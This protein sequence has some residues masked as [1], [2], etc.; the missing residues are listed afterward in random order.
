M[1]QVKVLFDYDAEQEDE[2]SLKVGEI[3]HNVDCHD[4]G[5]WEGEVNGRKGMFPENFVEVIEHTPE[6]VLTIPNPPSSSGS[7]SQIKYKARVT[8]QYDPVQEDELSLEVGEVVEVLEDDEE[9]WWT[10]RLN[11]KTGVF[12]SNFCE[13]IKEEEDVKPPVLPEPIQPETVNKERPKS[14]MGFMMRPEDLAKKLKKTSN[15]PKEEK[16]TTSFKSEPLKHTTHNEVKK[17]VM[18]NEAKKPITPNEVKKPITPN[19]MKKPVA[20]NEMKKESVIEKKLPPVPPP[21]VTA[22]KTIQKAKATFVYEPEQDD[23][24]KLS[25]GDIVVV[26]NIEVFEGWMEGELDGKRGLFPNNFVD[27]LPIETIKL[28][29][30]QQPIRSLSTKK[31]MKRAA[32]QDPTVKASTLDKPKPLGNSLFPVGSNPLKAELEKKIGFGKPPSFNKSSLNKGPAPP[33]PAAKPKPSIPSSK[34]AKPPAPAVQKPDISNRGVKPFHSPKEVAKTPSETS[35]AN[36]SI[37][38]LR[39]ASV[40]STGE[41]KVESIPRTFTGSKLRKGSGSSTSELNA[42]HFEA[43]SRRSITEE[44]D[45]N[46]ANDPSTFD[47]DSVRPTDPLKHLSRVKPPSKNLPSKF[48]D[49]T[50]SD[51]DV[52][53]LKSQLSDITEKMSEMERKFKILLN[54]VESDL[55]VERKARL[56]QQVEIDRLKKKLE[57]FANK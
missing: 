53:E 52:I 2:L 49:K 10:G 55:D 19:E 47:L 7:S 3:V 46:P 18:H 38:P 9:G 27:L 44:D 14:Q 41:R 54:Q 45:N 6:P 8:F 24:L 39:S 13:V 31:S 34:P 28:D 4:G 17:P 25:I 40:S 11:G 22:T 42:D 15:S 12:P 16:H 21:A 1:V 48:K 50:S 30:H 33:P 56:S 36:E 29:P 57:L 32:K 51:K 35:S 26:T 23:E 37:P 43:S 20:H 5:W